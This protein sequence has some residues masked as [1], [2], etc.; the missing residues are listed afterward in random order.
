MCYPG[1]RAVASS[2]TLE[3]IVRK[4]EKFPKK[5]PRPNIVGFL[6]YLKAKLHQKISQNGYF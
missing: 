1:G 6:K 4:S 5:Y 2:K 3:M